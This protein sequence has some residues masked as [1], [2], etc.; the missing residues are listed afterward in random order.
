MTMRI[1]IALIVI[2]AIITVATIII[3]M[4]TL[5]SRVIICT[6]P[7]HVCYGCKCRDETELIRDPNDE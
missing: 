2:V 3:I 6:V 1:I 5:N 4:D 7:N